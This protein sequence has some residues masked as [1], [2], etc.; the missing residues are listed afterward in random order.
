MTTAQDEKQLGAHIRWSYV[1]HGGRMAATTLVTFV[2]AVVLGPAAFGVIAVALVYV[3]FVQL[4]VQQGLLPALIQRDRL[5]DE[6]KDVAFWIVVT[7]SLVLG[8]A[9]VGLAG[10]LST[11]YSMPQLQ[12]VLAVLAVCLPIRAVSVVQEA[13]LQREMRF[14]ALALRDN[15]AVLSGGAVGIVAAFAGAGVWALVA[16]QVVTQAVASLA[17]C[18]TAR[19]H[20]R[21]RW[22]RIAARDLIGFSSHSALSSI[23]VF[24]SNRADILVMG[25]FFSPVAVGLYRLAFRLVDTVVDVSA[26]SMQTVSL[27]HLARLQGDRSGFATRLLRLLRLIGVLG[28]PAL[29]VLAASAPALVRVL[30]DEWEGVTPVL[31]L[32]CAAGALSAFSLLIGPVLQALGRPGLLAALAWGRALAG[33]A[34]FLAVGVLFSDASHADQV[35]SVAAAFL[36]LQALVAAAV[37]ALV[38]RRT[39]VGWRAQVRVMLPGLAAGLAAAGTTA[40]RETVGLAGIHPLADLA[41]TGLTALAAATAVLVV[42]DPTVRRMLLL[43]RWITIGAPRGPA[44]TTDLL[45]SDEKIGHRSAHS[46]RFPGNGSGRASAGE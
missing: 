39:S 35:S 25:L 6:H 29:G 10:P 45:L 31:R 20:P 37:V 41:V 8:A 16:Q 17:L 23:G 11:F 18:L 9:T 15:A 32:L 7:S 46:P 26:R 44:V 38:T 22:S 24:L 42:V 12:P 21:A 33:V 19:W 1:L 36:V 5:T 34:A 4:L 40:L 2:L 30:G 43:R 3:M 28:L 27:S 13:L 14:K